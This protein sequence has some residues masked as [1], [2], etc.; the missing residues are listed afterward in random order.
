[1]GSTVETLAQIA[2]ALVFSLGFGLYFLQI[3][4]LDALEC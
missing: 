4:A 3:L 2:A 1:L